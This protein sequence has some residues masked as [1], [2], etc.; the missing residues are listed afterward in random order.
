MPIEQM[1]EAKRHSASRFSATIAPN[2][3]ERLVLMCSSALFAGLADHEC[4]EIAASALARTFAR[5]ELLFSQGEPIRNLIL[6]QS[7]S[8]KLTQVSPNGNEVLLRI[9]GKGDAVNVRAESASCGH[10][11]SARATE[12][13][14]ALVWDYARIQ[15]YLAKYPRLRINVS[16]ILVTQL[17]ELEERFREVA[18][19]RVSR[20]LALLLLRLQA[21]IGKPTGEGIQISLSREELARMTGATVFTISRV[22]SEWSEKGLILTRREAIV[23]SHPERLG[24][25]C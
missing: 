11:N 23:V 6:L 13:C 24:E 7:G 9:N 21:Q 4:L 14:K 5:D 25:E 19:E 2:L 15:A 12:R 20:R 18:T 22:L 16:R 17:Q 3:G 10:T 8:V 1:I